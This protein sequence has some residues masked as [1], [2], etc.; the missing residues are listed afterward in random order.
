MKIRIQGNSIRLRLSKTDVEQ[1]TDEGIVVENTSFGS[2]VLSYAVEQN[3]ELDQLAASFEG[4]KITMQIPAT[5]VEDWAINNIV[6]FEANMEVGTGDTLYLLIE[7]DFKCL[8]QT[9]EDQSNQYENPKK[10]C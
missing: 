9:T 10:T 7:K 4:G 8:D 6:G 3:S 1:L 2:S 5:Y